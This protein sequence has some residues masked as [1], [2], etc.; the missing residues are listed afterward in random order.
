MNH[1][2]KPKSILR[3]NLS[4]LSK[5]LGKM[6]KF[7]TVFIGLLGIVNCFSII[8]E[9]DWEM[10]KELNAKNY[11]DNTEDD[12]RMNIFVQ[13]RDSIVHHNKLYAEKH[14]TFQIGFNEYSDMAH[15]EFVAKM[16]GFIPDSAVD[17]HQTEQSIEQT[18]EEDVSKS[19][20]IDWR[21]MGAVTGIKNQNLC[22]S[23]FAF[24]AIGALE[25]QLYRK[26]NKLVSFSEQHL[27]D[28]SSS[29][30]C[31]G[32]NINRAFE[33]IR[34]NYQI[35]S[36]KNSPYEARTG[37]CKIERQNTTAND[38]SYVNI[39][40]G[41]ERELTKMIEQIG[42]ISVA[43]DASRPSFKQYRKG[44]YYEPECDPLNLNHAV[45]V[46]GFGSDEN[47]DDY[48]LIKNSWGTSW[49]DKGYAKIAR[50]KNNHCGI[51]SAASYP[52]V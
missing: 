41:N 50:N 16:T 2:I 29:F 17:S 49:G 37:E 28:C 12:F 42:P 15:D 25:G 14:I 4:E 30:G 9:N 11:S 26:T 21:K 31:N 52:I 38:R 8:E 23:S 5:N 13:N 24:S 34:I 6:E 33:Y 39:P 44:I 7:S 27:I 19:N 1:T 47:G 20:E 43:L 40:F 48:Y 32:G 36:E 46:V 18:N 35:N 10:F 51:A 22:G 3:L 45:L